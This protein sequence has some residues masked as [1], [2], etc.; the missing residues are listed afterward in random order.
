MAVTA[1]AQL[2]AHL[3]PSAARLIVGAE[4]SMFSTLG[5]RVLGFVEGAVNRSELDLSGAKILLVDDMEANLDLLCELLESDG[6]DIALAD[7]GALALRLA[8]H[9]SPDLILLDVM[10]PDPGGLEVCRQLKAAPQTREIP[11]IF[12]TARDQTEDVVAGF[13]AGGV[14]YITKPFRDAEVSARVR[15]ALVTKRLFDQSKAYQAKIEKELQTAHDLQMGLMPSEKLRID[16]FDI[17]GQCAPAEQV[18]GDF[19]QYFHQDNCLIIA[20]ADVTGHA[21]EA[22]LPVVMFEG[23]LDTYM[24]LGE[25][26]LE[27]LFERLNDAMAERLSAHTYVC[28]SMAQ[29]DLTTRALRFANAGCPFPYKAKSGEITELPV[30]AYPLGVRAGTSY[31]GIETRLEP[32]DRLVFCSDG[33]MEARNAGGEQFGSSKPRQSSNRAVWKTCRRSSCW[34]AC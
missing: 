6:Y 1:H 7:G 8:D 17:S 5:C 19:F 30:S 13:N 3:A 24:R 26:R 34:K 27:D 18:G 14:D 4:Q 11:V 16:G 23:V 33:I 28:F 12:I 9:I 29:I 15:N 32:G 31:R 20:T 25:L 21:M 2:L 22:A 10:M